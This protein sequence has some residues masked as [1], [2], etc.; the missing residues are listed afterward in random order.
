MW[1][2]DNSKHTYIHTYVSCCHR[3]VEPRYLAMSFRRENVRY[4]FSED[5]CGNFAFSCYWLYRNLSHTQ[6]PV[7]PATKALSVP[8]SEDSRIDIQR[9]S[10]LGSWRFWVGCWCPGAKKKPGHQQPSLD[11]TDVTKLA[12]HVAREYTI[13]LYLHSSVLNFYIIIITQEGV[14]AVAPSSCSD[15]NS[16]HMTCL[17]LNFILV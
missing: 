3:M 6:N 1:Y 2:I 5:R 10:N 12:W 4:F 7:R 8:G 16:R 14:D 13:H 15:Y 11:F 9:M 17:R